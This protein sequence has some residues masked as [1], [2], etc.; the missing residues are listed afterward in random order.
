MYWVWS[1]ALQPRAPK[2]AIRVFEKSVAKWGLADRFQFDLGSAFE[3]KAFRHG[4]AQLGVHRNAVKPREPER[5]GKIEAYHRAL[6]RWFI[7]ELRLPGGASTS[8]TSSSS[9]RR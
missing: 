5:Q 2:A 8:S 6:I 1:C 4:L 9:S 3:S 7:N